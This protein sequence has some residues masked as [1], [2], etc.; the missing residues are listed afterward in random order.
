MR[1]DLGLITRAWAITGGVIVLSIVFVTS[2]NVGAFAIDRVARLYGT[3]F[4]AL[5]GYEDFVR[6][7]IS[8]AAMMFFPY[9][10][11]QR[12]HVFVDIISGKMSP[13]VQRALD[14]FSLIGMTAMALFMAYWMLLGMLETRDDHALSRV[15]GWPE[16]PFYFPGL[17][18]LILWAVIAFFQIFENQDPSDD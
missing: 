17:L 18:S 3:T 14:R 8:S 15:L 16:W 13:R 9:C 1:I 4:S 5:P 10:Q 12:G 7:A 11:Y 6:L 2:A